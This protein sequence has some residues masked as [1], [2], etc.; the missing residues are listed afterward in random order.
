MWGVS[1]KKKKKLWVKSI[2]LS[3]VK[4]NNFFYVQLL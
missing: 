4:H 2:T 1:N 3:T